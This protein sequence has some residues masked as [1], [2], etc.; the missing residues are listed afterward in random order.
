MLLFV[1]RIS[2]MGLI[3]AL[4][5]A[6]AVARLLP[7][8][9]NVAPIAAL[10]LLGGASLPLPWS[11]A[12]PT[13]AMLLS[14]LILGFDSFPITL[15]VY[16]SFLV[17]VF[18]GM[19]LR[20]R[21]TLARMVGASLGSSVLFYLVTNAA[22]WKFSG[23]YPSTFSGLLL[24]YLYALPFFRYSLIG[25]LVY[26]VALVGTLAYAPLLARKLF[27]LSSRQ[28]ATPNP[29]RGSTE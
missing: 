24:S 9:P 17:T 8:P 6:A 1:H 28:S 11:I 4:I 10:A 23:L 25:D 18:F 27:S 12:V 19:W 2:H 14:D 21:P 26:T 5:G 16:G 20:E 29:L 13:G 15:S 22:V 3:L 7:H